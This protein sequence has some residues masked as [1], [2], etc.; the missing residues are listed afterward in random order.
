MTTTNTTKRTRAERKT[1]RR[2]EWARLDAI[3]DEQA[4]QRNAWIQ[5]HLI[6]SGVVPLVD[7]IP[8]R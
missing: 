7:Y 1:A 3:K 6:S 2:E 4:R 5:K 8:P